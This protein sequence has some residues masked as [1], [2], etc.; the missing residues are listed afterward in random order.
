MPTYLWLVYIIVIDYDTV[1]RISVPTTIGQ[2]LFYDDHHVNTQHKN[3]HFR[4]LVQLFLPVGGN[5]TVHNNDAACDVIKL[6]SDITIHKLRNTVETWTLDLIPKVTSDM[7]TIFNKW[8]Y[9][10]R[11]T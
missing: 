10:I 7:Q 9:R 8:I 2:F 3:L 11:P 5:I 6:V 4:R 1:C